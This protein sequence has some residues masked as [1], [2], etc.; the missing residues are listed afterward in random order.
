ASVVI[1][2]PLVIVAQSSR[3]RDPVATAP[4]MPARAMS[5]PPA[6]PCSERGGTVALAALA[7]LGKA[8]TCLGRANLALTPD[9]RPWGPDFNPPTCG[10]APW[11]T[12]AA[13]T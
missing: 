7:L 4:R 8:P 10:R 13:S 3:R 2:S 9:F 11:S 5:D 12:T 1:G 6:L